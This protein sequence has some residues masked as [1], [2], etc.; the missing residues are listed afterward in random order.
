VNMYYDISGTSSRASSVSST[1][2]V[3]YLMFT[4]TARGILRKQ[5]QG[6]LEYKECTGMY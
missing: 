5:L 3:G 4:R 2:E 6:A 1:N